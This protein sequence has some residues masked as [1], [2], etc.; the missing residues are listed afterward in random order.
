M[1]TTLKQR[2]LDKCEQL[3]CTL[4]DHTS[5]FMVAFPDDDPRVWSSNNSHSITEYIDDKPNEAL[6]ELLYRM[7]YGFNDNGPCD[8]GESCETC[9]GQA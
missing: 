3:G 5:H 6:R 1:A 4:Y 9:S 2:V 7:S 8:D